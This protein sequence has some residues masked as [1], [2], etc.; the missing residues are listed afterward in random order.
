[1][2]SNTI[3][4]IINY[5]HNNPKI[6]KY[7]NGTYKSQKYDLNQLLP[8]IIYVLKNNISWRNVS[9]LKICGNI[10]WN[11]V[12][13]MHCKLIKFNVYKAVYIGLLITHYKKNKI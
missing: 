1:M 13:K 8:I 5:V 2:Y 4:E 11:T 9:D 7:F 12:Y 10:H 3:N 6:C